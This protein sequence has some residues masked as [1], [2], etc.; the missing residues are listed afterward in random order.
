MMVGDPEAHKK[1]WVGVLGAEVTQAGALEMFKLPGIFVIVGKAR[2]PPTEGSGGSSLNHFGFLV[3]SYAETKAKLAAAN[4]EVA[5]DHPENKQITVVFPEKVRV[6][7]T[8]DATLKVP[9]A[10]HHFHI[11]ATDP[12]SVRAWYVKTFGAVPG[13]RGIFPAAKL[14]GGEVDSLKA[15]EA[16]APTKGRSLDH[17][18]FEVK[19][20]EAFCKKLQADGVTFD[21][22]YREIPQL[23][24]LKI[25]FILDPVGT[26]IELTEGLAS[27]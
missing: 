27:H 12:E 6:E 19:G 3:R 26:R 20:L 18:G 5:T 8:E 23:A 17:I 1:L 9:I 15:Q 16:Q 13:T 10:F 11:S 14:P 4:V 21:M 24:G 25:A 22:A 7:F 2:T